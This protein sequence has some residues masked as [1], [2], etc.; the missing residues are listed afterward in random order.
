VCGGHKWLNAPVGRGFLYVAPHQAE[1]LRPPSWGYLGIAE[2]PEGWAEYFATPT[3]PAVRD[4]NFVSGARRFE[5]SGTANYPGNVVLG[6]SLALLNG[7]GISAI[8]DHVMRLGALLI[9]RLKAAGAHIVSA[10]ERKNRSGIVTF[11]VGAGPAADADLLR[12]LL[13]RQILISQ[14]Y[15]AGVGGLRV[16]V[17]CFN[18]EDDVL[19][20]AEAVSARSRS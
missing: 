2:P 1:R 9:D 18:N 12:K 10:E 11:T 6:A 15:T 4:Y 3:I 5:V 8:E 16:S 19:A 7:V 14:R 17:H 20:L 13:A